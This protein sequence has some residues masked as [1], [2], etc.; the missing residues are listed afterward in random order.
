MGK[1]QESSLGHALVPWCYQVPCWI[2][3]P[4][5]QRTKSWAGYVNLV[6]I[7]IWENR[8]SNL[9]G[10]MYWERGQGQEEGA[11][12]TASFNLF[13]CFWFSFLKMPWLTLDTVF[14]G[15]LT[16]CVVRASDYSFQCSLLLSKSKSNFWLL[17]ST[18][19]Y[20]WGEDAGFEELCN[21]I[22]WGLLL[23]KKKTKLLIYN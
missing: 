11:S 15:S 23:R 8:W 3:E 17:L 16:R 12:N 19:K 22:I 10:A 13:A 1:I 14:Q 6:A 4:R 7:S 21:Y 2:Y 20:Q 18:I 5:A 9:E